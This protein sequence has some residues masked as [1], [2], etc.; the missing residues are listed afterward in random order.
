MITLASQ[1]TQSV[2]EDLRLR[3]FSVLQSYAAQ[4]QPVNFTSMLSSERFSSA[5]TSSFAL[6][7]SFSTLTASAAG[8]L[9]KIRVTLNVSWTE[10]RVPFTR[11]VTTYFSE[12]GLSD[13]YYVGWAP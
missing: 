10:N 1:V 2:M 6:S 9:G 11:T 3:N 8:T 13:Y 7:G 4:S 5:F 12:K